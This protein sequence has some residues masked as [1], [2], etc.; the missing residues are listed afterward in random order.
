MNDNRC[1]GRVYDYSVS[2]SFQCANKGK[3]RERKKWYCGIHAPSKIKERE[4]R[5]YEK[6]E[7]EANKI[8]AIRREISVR[9]AQITRAKSLLWEARKKL[10]KLYPGESE[11]EPKP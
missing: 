10:A 9:E 5:R 3:Y 7:R 2:Q 11:K 6:E 4:D 8:E 1:Q